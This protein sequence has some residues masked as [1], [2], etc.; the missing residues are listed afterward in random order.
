M[1]FGGVSCRMGRYQ[2][3]DVHVRDMLIKG[4][5]QIECVGS[6]LKLIQGKALDVPLRLRYVHVPCVLPT[7]T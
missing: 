2:G 5:E 6:R 3:E 1:T 7:E 4:E